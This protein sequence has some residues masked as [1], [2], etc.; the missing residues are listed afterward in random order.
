MEALTSG[1]VVLKGM[2]TSCW[3]HDGGSAQEGPRGCGAH[4]LVENGPEHTGDTTG[5]GCALRSHLRKI[6][7][8]SMDAGSLVLWPTAP[9]EPFLVRQ[10]H[11]PGGAAW[12]MFMQGDA[13]LL[14]PAPVPS[15]PS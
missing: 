15:S 8:F 11:C 14:P 1:L 3:W 2:Q 7:L 6:K 5:E 10:L 9:P 13:S 12:R 4:N